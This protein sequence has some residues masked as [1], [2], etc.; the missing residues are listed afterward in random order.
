LRRR[1]IAAKGFKQRK[2]KRPHQ[3]K[4]VKSAIRDLKSS[5]A[6]RT[7]GVAT[8]RKAFL[9]SPDRPMKD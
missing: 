7:P 3:T 6:W 4:S 8:I 2:T 9:L 5:E 1:A